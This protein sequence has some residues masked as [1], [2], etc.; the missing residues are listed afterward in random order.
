MKRKRDIR[1]EIVTISSRLF[2]KKG[3]DGVS[4][5]KIAKE[6]GVSKSSIFWHFGSKKALYEE[7]L[8]KNIDNLKVNLERALFRLSPSQKMLKLLDLC[9][10]FLLEHREFVQ[11]LTRT[12]PGVTP[13]LRRELL[14]M[15]HLIRSETVKILKEAGCDTIAEELANGIVTIIHGLACQISSEWFSS[16][17][18]KAFRNGTEKLVEWIMSFLQG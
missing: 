2:A 4:V 1:D 8:R 9:V 10:D 17:D 14:K 3:Y 6:S 5:E 12:S 13:G 16:R 18:L 11:I 15:N 7:V